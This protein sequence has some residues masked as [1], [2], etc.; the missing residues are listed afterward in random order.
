MKGGDGFGS[1]FNE[2]KAPFNHLSKQMDISGK[3]DATGKNADIT[4]AAGGKGL[5][6]KVLDE[7]P[8]KTVKQRGGKMVLTFSLN[9]NK[10]RCEATMVGKSCR[11]EVRRV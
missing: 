4:Q 5:R 1:F 9:G 2:V 3:L 10:F 7:M 11:Y 6:K 8:K